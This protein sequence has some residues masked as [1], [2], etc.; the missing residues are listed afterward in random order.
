[1]PEGGRSHV[2]EMLQSL[3]AERFNIKSHPDKKEFPVYALV[4]G[5]GGLKMT[6]LPEGPP[7]MS[8]N[9]EV[10]ATGGRGGVNVDLGNGAYFGFA[11]NKL[12]GK[13]LTMPRFAD[14]LTMFADRPV[15]DNTGLKG[16]YDFT[17]QLSEEDYTAMLIRSALKNGVTL[18][19][20]ALRALEA[21]GDTLL[22]AVQMLGLKLEPRKEPLDVIVIDSADKTPI[23]N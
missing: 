20:Q 15:I 6:E 16:A 17:I 11:N 21:S 10:K 22:N 7:D 23:E 12:E 13:R 14:M 9:V 4:V 8:G 18:P 2:R 3:L 1:M 5:K 19:P